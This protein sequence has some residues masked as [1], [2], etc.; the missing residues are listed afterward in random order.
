L[1]NQQNSSDHAP[2]LFIEDAQVVTQQSAAAGQIILKLQASNCASA[3]LPGTFVKLSS[4]KSSSPVMAPIMRAD[5][6][7]GWIEVLY[8][9]HEPHDPTATKRHS[10]RLTVR[11]PIGRAF[12]PTPHKHRALLVGH[13]MGIA[14]LVFLAERLRERTDHECTLLVLL[15]SDLPFPFRARPSTIV[16]EGMPEG[17][18]ACMPMLDEWGVPSRLAS[19]SGDP[20]CYDGSVVD[21]ASVWLSSLDREVLKDV[22]IFACGPRSI[23]E[24]IGS[25][26]ERFGV[27]RQWL[28]LE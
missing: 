13:G 25:T 21:L 7:R 18:I 19:S 3:A 17:T 15:E 11:G 1:S 28:D 16:V 26:T 14:P 4:D 23:L 20:G 22:E 24:G 8:R 12:N 2:S 27:S 5:T 6:E 10:D 9:S